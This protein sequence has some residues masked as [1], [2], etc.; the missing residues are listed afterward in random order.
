MSSTVIDLLNSRAGTVRMLDSYAEFTHGDEIE[1]DT[2]IFTYNQ[3]SVGEEDPTRDVIV[4]V[5]GNGNTSTTTTC[6][7]ELSSPGFGQ[8]VSMLSVTSADVVT[9]SS[10]IY[11]FRL[12]V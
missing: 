2:S 10:F 4:F 9:S 6:A 12:P 1:N 7:C 11:C 3:V 8:G 5:V